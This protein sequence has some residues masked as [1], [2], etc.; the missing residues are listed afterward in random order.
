MTVIV[1]MWVVRYHVNV[2]GYFRRD[3]C[4]L[5]YDVACV[6]DHVGA[7][8]GGDCTGRGV[9]TRPEDGR[10]AQCVARLGGAAASAGAE[11]QRGGRRLGPARHRRS[12]TGSRPAEGWLVTAGV[13]WGGLLVTSPHPPVSE[14]LYRDVNM[15]G[16][17]MLSWVCVKVTIPP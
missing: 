10:A 12:E 17:I 4:R 11:L 1:K 5:L 16:R 6:W 8:G 2:N 15:G 14:L 3:L 9:D 13:P 7:A